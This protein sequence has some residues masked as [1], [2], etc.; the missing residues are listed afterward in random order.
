MWPSHLL[1]ALLA[2]LAAASLDPR[3][4]AAPR[5]ASYELN[6]VGCPVP[7]A[8]TISGSTSS[9][10]LT[11]PD[12]ISEIRGTER[13]DF[14]RNCLA[15]LRIEEGVPGYRLAIR[16]VQGEG[17]FFGSPDVRLRLQS[18][19]YFQNYERLQVGYFSSLFLHL[20]RMFW[21]G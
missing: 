7:G 19:A 10:S 2:P 13:R 16:R 20:I 14:N 4:L 17:M 21:G 6:G 11:L 1:P 9:L 12:F 3:A 5:L 8:S 15:V 18:V